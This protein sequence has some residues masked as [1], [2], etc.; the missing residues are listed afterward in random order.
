MNGIQALPH[1]HS[2]SGVEEIVTI[3]KALPTLCFFPPSAIPRIFAVHLFRYLF[4]A[5]TAGTIEILLFDS[6]SVIIVS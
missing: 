1:R 4:I 5:S 2:T 6:T 3:Y